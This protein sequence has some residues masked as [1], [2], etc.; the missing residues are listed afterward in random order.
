[1]C[2]THHTIPLTWT[3]LTA[4]KTCLHSTL[5]S[6]Y[7]QALLSL[8]LSTLVLQLSSKHVLLGLGN[9]HGKCMWLGL[10]PV[11]LNG[12]LVQAVEWG[13]FASLHEYSRV[14]L[15]W[16]CDASGRCGGQGNNW[17]L[18]IVLSNI[19]H[20]YEA[21]LDLSITLGPFLSFVSLTLACSRNI[22]CSR[23]LEDSW[24]QLSPPT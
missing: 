2:S 23:S 22:T 16:A 24:N 3:S 21:M 10:I 6:C 4:L 17:A 5:P 15:I 8:E 13:G 20:S 18:K 19:L 11:A 9:R 1:M 7:T 14:V 12:P